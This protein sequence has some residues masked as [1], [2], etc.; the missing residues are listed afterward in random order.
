MEDN[1][2]SVH[3]RQKRRVIMRERRRRCIRAI[4]WYGLL[5]EVFLLPLSP[6]A[7][8]AALLI[9]SI[10]TGL[11]LWKDEEFHFRHLP[12]DVPAMLFVV[13]S[14]LS[15]LASPNRAFSFYN[16]YNLVG[17]Y[18]LTYLLI[19]QNVRQPQQMKIMLRV[20]GVSAVLVIL[21]GYYQFLFGIDISSMKWVDGDAF[22]ELRKRV[23]STWENPNILAGY[24]DIVICLAFGL[25]MHAGK[26][27][28]RTI[29]GVFML[30]AA[31]CLAMTY[32]RGACLVIAVILAGYG[33][34][35]D[36]RVLLA[37][38]VVGALLLAADPVLYERLTSVFTKVD[39]STEMRLAFWE[40]TVAMIQ[41]HPFLGIGWGAYWM[42]YP[43]YDFY[44][45]GA[46]ILIVHA[47]NIYLNYMAEIG[48][49]GAVAFFWFFF[50]TMFLALHQ[51]FGGR[52]K[53]GEQ[54]L[55]RG[56]SLG[57]GLAVLSVALNGLTDDLLFNIPSSMV[58]WMMAA[59]TGALSFL[60]RPAADEEK[61]ALPFGLD[62]EKLRAIGTRVSSL[63]QAHGPSTEEFVAE[64]D[65]NSENTT[66]PET[67]TEAASEKT[68]A[69]QEQAGKKPADDGHVTISAE[70][71]AAIIE[72]ASVKKS[73]AQETA[74]AQDPAAP[75][76]S[77]TAD[78]DAAAQ[79]E[80]QAAEDKTDTA[81]KADKAAKDGA[82]DA[83]AVADA[84]DAEET[85][86]SPDAEEASDEQ[87]DAPETQEKEDAHEGTDK[88]IQ[89]DH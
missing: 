28:M 87:A 20:A 12:F 34:L 68:E 62:E 48:I 76:P 35:K 33:A 52:E 65:A 56:L 82:D 17:V 14:A 5:A 55:L 86:S 7:A 19:G 21:Y 18:V 64:K 47:H 78:G 73:D 40:S 41:D 42:V 29:F 81:D 27:K 83:D 54:R 50:G 71:I 1:Q 72:E 13:I 66:A 6:G 59:L 25:F 9:A 51:P 67:K 74:D 16:Y 11:R 43:E 8:T 85:A 60:S 46:D 53:E 57:L 22:P 10:A 26:R 37:C 36:R 45:Q 79:A 32:A 4:A 61:Q 3:I 80:E 75:Q 38:V 89:G 88:H 77:E 84:A 15:V 39:T 31:A 23:F 49:P 24:L 58:L 70:D 2:T 44:L 63:W 30:A 69:P